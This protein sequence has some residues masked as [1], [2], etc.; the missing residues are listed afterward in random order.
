MN[1][2]RG[3]D[4]LNFKAGNKKGCAL[5][6]GNFDGIH[7]GHQEILKQLRLIATRDNLET[8]V[9]LFHPNPKVYFAKQ[10][11]YL[12]KKSFTV[13]RAVNFII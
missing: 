4:F 2:I 10:K 3:N 11:I 6:I 12:L 13:K 9:M 8:A 7:K 1:L 5:A